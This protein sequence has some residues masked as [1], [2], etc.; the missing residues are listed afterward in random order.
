MSKAATVRSR[1][2]SHTIDDDV[3]LPLTKKIKGGEV[4]ET[5]SEDDDR[6]QRMAQAVKTV[7]EVMLS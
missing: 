2:D 4:S 1:S 6:L 7:I 3:E 5:S